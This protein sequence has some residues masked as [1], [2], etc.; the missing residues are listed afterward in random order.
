MLSA[1]ARYRFVAIAMFLTPALCVAQVRFRGQSF[2][3]GESN[4]LVS[5]SV[6]GSTATYPL[7]MN[8][9]GVVTGY[10]LDSAQAT[11]GFVRDS[12]GN[13]ST[14]NVPGSVL[15]LPTSINTAGDIAG[16]YEITAG[17][18]MG[19][20]R[21]PNGN[22]TTFGNP[23][24]TVNGASF[25]AQPVAL[26]VAGEIVGNF[27]NNTTASE[28][29]VRTPTGEVETFSL[30]LG[31][32]YPTVVSGLNAGGAVVG[33]SSSQGLT[34][35]QG[36]YWSGQ[37]PLPNF[38]GGFTPITVPDSTATFPTAINAEGTIAGCYNAAGTYYDFVRAADGT[39]T[40][41]NLP[42]AV[43]ACLQSGANGVFQATHPTVLLNDEGVIA[44]SV[45]SAGNATVG[46]VRVANGA[47]TE[48][49]FPE[50]KLTMP[51]SLNNAGQITG[52]YANGNQVVGFIRIPRE[53]I[54]EYGEE[55]AER[56]AGLR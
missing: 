9:A 16:Y 56:V 5:F 29:F 38:G 44:G 3:E 23:A 18:P 19:F 14:F 32:S 45:T 49:A 1:S 55:G 25:W 41:L 24:P 15:T 2:L 39:F 28:A 37:G 7:S 53:V 17:T 42:G 10:Y 36:F 48:F 11:H 22:F 51:T 8:E 13:I 40:T 6:P 47:T 46:F 4:R 50:S 30:S 20:L 52:Y 31:E 33:Y 43:P 35:S 54:S 34:L 21:D 26:N 27:P 12:D